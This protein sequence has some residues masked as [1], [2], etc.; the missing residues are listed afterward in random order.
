MWNVKH[1]PRLALLSAGQLS[2]RRASGRYRLVADK[3]DRSGERVK[4]ETAETEYPETV[5][6]EESCNH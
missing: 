2:L 5:Y 6:V 1:N 4:L 3:A